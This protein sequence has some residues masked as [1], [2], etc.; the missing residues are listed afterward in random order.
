MDVSVEIEIQNVLQD[1]YKENGRKLKQ[2]V[3][4]I[5]Y[6]YGGLSEKDKDDFYSIANHTI[7]EIIKAIDDPEAERKYDPN[8]GN[9][10]GYIYRAISLAII[11]DI[12]YRNAGKRSVHYIDE[13]GEKIFLPTISIDAP[14]GEDDSFTVGDFLCS[15]SDNFDILHE[16]GTEDNMILD[17]KMQ[18]YL[19]SLTETQRSILQLK[20]KGFS[21]EEIRTKLKLSKKQYERQ[22]QEIKSYEHTKFLYRDENASSQTTKEDIKMTPV[23]TTSE[24]YKDAHYSIE[25]IRKKL[26]KYIWRD[27]HP[28]QRHAAQWN[29]YSKSELISDILQGKPLGQIIVSEEIKNGVTMYWIID[30]KQRCTNIDDFCADGFAIS[31]KVQ[32]PLITYQTPKRDENGEQMYNEDKFPI[33]EFKSFDIRKKRFHQLPEELQ[34]KILEYQMP[35]MLNLNCTKAEIAYDIAR[36]NRSRPMNA[37]QNGWTGID[38]AY[39]EMIDNIIKL[40]FFKE[41]FIGSNYTSKNN[42]S[43]LMR[44]VI[45][46]SIMTI[47]FIND[48]NRDF[49]KNCEY[50]SDEANDMVFA[51]FYELVERLMEVANEE[52]AKIFNVKDSFLWF[53]VFNECCNYNISDTQFVEFVEQFNVSLHSKEVDGI[54]FDSLCNGRTKNENHVRNR[55]KF[56][57]DLMLGYFDIEEEAK[58]ETIFEF[59]SSWAEYVENFINT[60]LMQFIDIKQVDKERIAVQ[61]YMLLDKEKD[62]SDEFMQEYIDNVLIEDEVTGDILSLYMDMLN[63]YTLEMDDNTYKLNPNQIPALIGATKYAVKEEIDKQTMVDLIKKWSTTMDCSADSH[64]KNENYRMMI[65]DL[66]YVGI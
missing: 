8:K 51:S 34:D 25:S 58:E 57:I 35:T 3:D 4:N 31:K 29:L 60:D 46:E 52:T 56:I 33:F 66:E 10:T 19:D 16:I 6:K 48:F 26:K 41:D 37:N 20:T 22:M 40:N 23:I 54:S 14:I 32:R 38:E 62:F 43:G 53:A 64:D 65:N 5:T 18:K 9:F 2:M 7:S 28:L 36:F 15:Q 12:K 17:E 11:D 50:I 27:D 42:S 49:R 1:H 47:N 45:V 30:G 61:T 44:R 21:T 63:D 55:I 59:D 13:H 24:K 39:A